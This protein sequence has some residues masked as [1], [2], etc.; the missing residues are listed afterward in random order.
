MYMYVEWIQKVLCLSMSYWCFFI[1][2]CYYNISDLWKKWNGLWSW[3]V[4]FSRLWHQLTLK[5][6]AFIKTPPFAKGDSLVRVS[7]FSVRG[8]MLQCREFLI[9]RFTNFLIDP[10]AVLSISPQCQTAV[11]CDC[12]FGLVK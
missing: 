9:F 2:V 5:L 6:S 8:A 11:H 3:L 12:E 1:V 7:V 10:T 4:F